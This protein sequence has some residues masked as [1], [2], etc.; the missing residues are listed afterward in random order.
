[1]KAEG[2]SVYRLREEMS[3]TG[4][5]DYLPTVMKQNI[6]TLLSVPLNMVNETVESA[7][8]QTSIW[9]S[10]LVIYPNSHSSCFDQA[11]SL[12]ILEL[13]S[14]WPTLFLDK[15]SS[16]QWLYVYEDVGL[17]MPTL[18]FVLL[19]P[20]S[21]ILYSL[22]NFLKNPSLFDVNDTNLLWPSYS[23]YDFSA[24]LETPNQ[25]RFLKK[26]ID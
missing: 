5:M 8:K 11:W 13:P 21:S 17:S 7:Q 1:M 20:Q 9:R 26:K 25:L 22:E 23:I 16:G 6:E 19:W 3:M 12:E 4:R 18:T 24:F 10:Y 15:I 14:N 2:I